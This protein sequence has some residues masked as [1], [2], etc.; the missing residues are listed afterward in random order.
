MYDN[1]NMRLCVCVHCT[2]IESK[3]FHRKSQPLYT[4]IMADC[5]FTP[6]RKKLVKTYENEFPRIDQASHAILGLNRHEGDL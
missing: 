5:A 3:F 4:V 1:F 2:Q 6:V